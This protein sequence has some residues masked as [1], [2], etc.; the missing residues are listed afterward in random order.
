MKWAEYHLPHSP[1]NADETPHKAGSS[2]TP[3]RKA[4]HG[5]MRA[6]AALVQAHPVFCPHSLGGPRAC[7]RRQGLSDGPCIYLTLHPCVTRV[8]RTRHPEP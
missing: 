6:A 8:T 7:L 5:R 2:E 3:D 1:D 4:A